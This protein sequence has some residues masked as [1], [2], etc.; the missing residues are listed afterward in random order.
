MTIILEP[1]RQTRLSPYTIRFF[2]EDRHGAE[3]RSN[4]IG[5]QPKSMKKKTKNPLKKCFPKQT[6]TAKRGKEPIG[7]HLEVEIPR[8]QISA[9][10]ASP[11]AYTR[12]GIAGREKEIYWGRRRPTAAALFAELKKQFKTVGLEESTV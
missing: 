1:Q 7:T 11:V 10:F 6:T 4:P 8:S 3:T 12:I 9:A 2:A 5:N